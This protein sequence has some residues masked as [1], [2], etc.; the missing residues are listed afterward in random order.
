METYYRPHLLSNQVLSYT[1]VKSIYPQRPHFYL[2]VWR[3]ISLI[4]FY[5]SQPFLYPKVSLIS[6]SFESLL[7][8][9]LVSASD[10]FSKS[11]I[12]ALFLVPSG[13]F[14]WGGGRRKENLGGRQ[15]T[16]CLARGV[17]GLPV[18]CFPWVDMPDPV[19][20]QCFL[21]LSA[22][23]ALPEQERIYLHTSYRGDIYKCLAWWPGTA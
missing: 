3:N 15:W 4:I 14:R 17:G 22:L 16:S 7:S 2:Q 6:S 20:A 8:W 18:K 13:C 23:P 11:H 10:K 9:A 12:F 19:F 5:A 1:E 21:L